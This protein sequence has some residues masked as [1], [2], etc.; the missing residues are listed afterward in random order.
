M[1]GASA[2]FW[3]KYFNVALYFFTFIGEGVTASG[4]L[5]TPLQPRPAT[6]GGSLDVLPLQPRLLPN[7]DREC[8]RESRS[9]PREVINGKIRRSAIG[10]LLKICSVPEINLASVPAMAIGSSTEILVSIVENQAGFRRNSFMSINSNQSRTDVSSEIRRT[11]DM[12]LNVEETIKS[13]DYEFAKSPSTEMTNPSDQSSTPL[14]PTELGLN[15]NFEQTWRICDNNFAIRLLINYLRTARLSPFSQSDLSDDSVSD[16][17]YLCIKLILYLPVGGN[18]FY[19]LNVPTT[20]IIIV[21]PDPESN[22][23]LIC[24]VK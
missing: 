2:T 16:L 9:E 5:T 19:M 18:K 1:L 10:K 4:N 21:H 13:P 6:T 20:S 12:N 15:N 23:S 3:A 22:N 14:D 17:A 8:G 7:F 11:T 24:G